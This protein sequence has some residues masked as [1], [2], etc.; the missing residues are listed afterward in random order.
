MVAN[1]HVAEAESANG[2]FG[3]VDPTQRHGDG[4]A[5][6]D[7]RRQAG[8]GRAVPHRQTGVERRTGGC[9][10]WSCRRR[11][12]GTV[13][14]ARRR[15]AGPGGGRAGRRC[16]PRAGRW[17][18][19]WPRS[20]PARPS[21]PT[22]T[23]STDPNRCGRTGGR[24]SRRCRRPPGQ[25]P[26][27]SELPTVVELALGERRGAGG[28][29]QNPVGPEVAE[30]SVREHCRVDTTR[31]G[32]DDR[33]E[34]GQLVGESCDAAR[35]RSARGSGRR[36]EARTSMVTAGRGVAGTPVR[37]D[38]V[39]GRRDDRSFRRRSRFGGAGARATGGLPP[40]AVRAS[41][42]IDDH[43]VGPPR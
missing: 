27:P 7:A 34:G 17:R 41:A 5:V 40:G 15:R 1:P 4:V 13:R 39:H 33:S 24:R 38:S 36:G 22:C 30:R 16:S 21:A 37:P 11:P 9:S 43:P 18:T 19:A 2:R 6:G 23:R 8:H 26:F 12:S 14:R 10:P 20:V 3:P 32:H 28:H 35:R 25:G 42:R 31:E 29:G